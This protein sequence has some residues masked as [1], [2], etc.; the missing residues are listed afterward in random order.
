VLL[1]A[2]ALAST[3][4]GAA[5]PLGRPALAAEPYLPGI[6]VSHWQGSINWAQVR[7]DGIRFAFAKATQGTT[8]V[9]DRYA[10]N[11]A[12]ATAQGIAF[13]AYHFAEPGGGASDAIAEA[14]HFV[15]T[16]SLGGKNLLPV[17]DLEKDYG[18]SPRALRRWAKAWL[19]RVEAR[20]GVKAIIYTNY[21]FWRDEVGDPTW[22][23]E[24]GHPLWIA[25]YGVLEPTVPAQNWAGDG[26]TVWQH[27][28]KGS[29]SGIAG[30][31]DRNWF[32]GTG[33]APLKIK[34]SR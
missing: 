18:L 4:V 1:L 26:W 25:R 21:F 2:A 34:N 27:T 29:V 15:D 13:G 22:F 24:Q 16:A 7:G 11:K 19:A 20:L 8:F 3:L 17:L 28:N 6:D 12:G 14:D 30:N 23:A 31:V 5:T 9:D 10:T 32:D 33:L